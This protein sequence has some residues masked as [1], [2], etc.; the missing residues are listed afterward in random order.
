MS[1]GRTVLFLGAGAS[2]PFG[3][4][5]TA[6]ILPEVLRRLEP[7]PGELGDLLGRFLPA[8]FRG[9]AEAP[10]ITDLLSLVD[11]LIATRNAP[12][13]DLGVADL[14]RLRLLLERAVADVLAEPALPPG[15]GSGDC[16]TGGSAGFMGDGA[17]RGGTGGGSAA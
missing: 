8:L 2:R 1:G 17:L 16:R 4:P 3:F 11:H 14:D 12:Q 9:A 5:V 10:L 7:S 13:P 6:E 15:D